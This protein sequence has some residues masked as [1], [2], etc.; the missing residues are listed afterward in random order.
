MKSLGLKTGFDLPANQIPVFLLNA[1]VLGA[2]WGLLRCLSGSVMVASLSHGVWNGITYVLFGFGS[3]VGALGIKDTTFYGPEV[4]VL[5]LGV[6]VV[7]FVALW[8]WR[9]DRM[10]GGSE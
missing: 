9:K 7:F 10:W 5:G 2:V 1:A 4:G 8:W 6:N 3:T